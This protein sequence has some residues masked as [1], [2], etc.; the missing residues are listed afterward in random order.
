MSNS[1][2]TKT[3]REQIRHHKN[4]AIQSYFYRR[5]YRHE[6]PYHV[7]GR[8]QPLRVLLIL[9]HMRSGSSLLTHILNDNP[10]ILGYGETHITYQS[11]DDFKQLMARVYWRCHE[12]KKLTDLQYLRMN[13]QYVLDK[14]LHNKLLA[15]ESLLTH[16]QVSVIFL[17]REP[18]GSLS[19]LQKLKPHLTDQER[20]R[21]YKNRL[22]KLGDYAE[23]IGDREKALWVTYETLLNQTQ[24]VLKCFQEF[25]GTK[26]PFSEQYKLLATTGKRW[27]GDSQ[28]KIKTG[29][30]IRHPA[31]PNYSLSDDIQAEANLVYQ[32]TCQRLLTFCKPS[33][34]PS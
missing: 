18:A 24:P 13:H 34:Q 7:W 20:F 8:S 31:T 10:A 11:P 6:S 4:Q 14:I 3:W 32:D 5:I 25:L 15:D 29:K 1:T 21:Y 19:S 26:V 23:F 16:P 27:V 9:G 12:F 17:V 28:G 33:I 2:S 22:I 30:I